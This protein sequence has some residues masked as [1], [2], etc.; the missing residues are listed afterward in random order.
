[1]DDVKLRELAVTMA[2]D[3]EITPDVIGKVYE[4]ML[5]RSL[6]AGM[7]TLEAISRQA[8]E[9][10]EISAA[11]ARAADGVLVFGP[12][13]GSPYYRAAAFEHA[14]TG[15]GYVAVIEYDN[16]PNPS[17]K[18]V[19][20]NIQAARGQFFDE[21]AYDR[22]RAARTPCIDEVVVCHYAGDPASVIAK[23]VGEK[24]LEERMF[25]VS[26]S[27]APYCGPDAEPCEKVWI[28]GQQE[29]LDLCRWPKFFTAFK[30]GIEAH[31][32]S[33]TFLAD[34]EA[35]AN[36]KFR[37]FTEFPEYVAAEDAGDLLA[38]ADGYLPRDQAVSGM[39]ILE[40]CHAQYGM[41]KHL[42]Q[43]LNLHALCRRHGHDD[44]GTQFD[45]ND[46]RNIAYAPDT[47]LADLDVL[48]LRD[49]NRNFIVTFATD[50]ANATIDVCVHVFGNMKTRPSVEWSQ[51]LE[52]A[53]DGEGVSQLARFV[54]QNGTV[55]VVMGPA[56]DD[57]S[58]RSWNSFISDIETGECC[59][60]EEYG[61]G[62]EPSEDPVRP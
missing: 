10:G 4:T 23:V 24:Y 57:D 17:L 25:S 53:V 8:A 58:I 62:E 16:K 48:V 47:A 1:M 55:T 5:C 37:Q 7:N 60:L 3:G 35:Y 28:K 36:R 19:H 14:G 46:G 33:E 49:S 11:T 20:R 6:E 52:E 54:V 42:E 18:E 32:L 44:T 27:M 43:M 45:H 61:E 59:L 2:A 34:A 31:G 12:G 13:T 38:R 41:Q 21:E 22:K 29:Y 56:L 15:T 30:A 40:A 9:A 51:A 39:G 50:G 26:P